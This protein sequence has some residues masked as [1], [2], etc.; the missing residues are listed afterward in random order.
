MAT[1]NN[2]TGDRM[3]TKTTSEEYRNNWD[4]IFGKKKEAVKEDEEDNPLTSEDE[5]E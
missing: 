5:E 4:A 3:V 2:I 1:R